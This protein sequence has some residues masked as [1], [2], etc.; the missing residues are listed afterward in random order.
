[1]KILFGIQGTGNGHITRSRELLKYLVKKAEVDVLVS[2]MHHEINME[3]DIKY[4]LDGLGFMFGKRGG[5]DYWKSIR[6]ASPR[7]LFSDIYSLPVDKYDLVISDFEPITAWASKIRRKPYVC[8][9]HQASFL[10]S[11]IPRPNH[12]N[13]LQQFVMEWYAPGSNLIGLHFKEY[14]NFIYTPII[15][16]GI[17]NTDVK[18]SGHYTVYLP[19]YDESYITEILKKIDV[20]WEIFSKHYK[21]D[22]FTEN[23]VTVYQ[24]ENSRFIESLSSCEGLLCNAG[25][26]TPAETLYLGKKLMVIPMKYQ[27]EQECNAEALKGL[28]I[29]VINEIG[30]DFKNSLSDWINS[31]YLY[32]ANYQ[33]NLPEIVDRILDFQFD[34]DDQG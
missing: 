12:K 23:N 31:S 2:G 20:P 28:G 5:I 27:Y 30:G 32:Q 7:K 33:N 18:N 16:E 14:D 9:S 13:R 8:I 22:P 34:A 29:A 6:C 1:M 26:E 17:R 24:V 21:G 4:E 19:S 3:I 10:S 15:R 25:F 11:K